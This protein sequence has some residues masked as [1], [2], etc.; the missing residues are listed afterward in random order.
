MFNSKSLRSDTPLV[1]IKTLKF[2]PYLQAPAEVIHATIAALAPQLDPAGVF[3]SSPKL[4]PYLLRAIVCY[5]GHHYKVYALSEELGEWLL[6]D[7]STISYIGG[8]SEVKASLGASRMQPNL[9][10]YEQQ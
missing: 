9:L 3:K 8:W 6:Y 1:N 5:F 10:F 4:P 2:V 7:D